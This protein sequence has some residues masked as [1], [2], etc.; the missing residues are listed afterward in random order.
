[1]PVTISS[2]A[3]LV[4]FNNVFGITHPVTL[5]A[6][7][8]LTQGVAFEVSLYNVRAQVKGKTQQ[9]NLTYGTTALMKGTADAVVLSQNKKL[10][11]EWVTGLYV[12]MGSPEAQKAT[13]KA[14]VQTAPIAYRVVLLGVTHPLPHLLKLV[15]AVH[16]VTGGTVAAAKKKVDDAVAGATVEI[17]TYP[18]LEAANIAAA[19][20]TA[21]EGHLQFVP[22]VPP[23]VTVAPPQV[24]GGPGPYAWAK[25]VDQVIDLKAAKAL[26][27]KV[28]GTSTGSVY[29]T[30][31]I[32][33]HVKVAARLYTTGSISIRA[34]WTDNPTGDLKLLAEAG[35]QMKPSYGSIHFDAQDVPLQRVIGA[36]LLGTG[37]EWQQVVTKGA[38]LV[39]GE[40]K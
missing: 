40:Y 21:A 13:L 8:L 1:M 18:S 9:V 19:P 31:A 14:P 10:I 12:S 6:K 34:E 16:S 3:Q 36:F 28:H 17:G 37:I 4:F 5:K 38:D 11:E 39:I 27:Q 26:G 24:V 35:L 7:V 20:I 23:T 2:E 15:K 22:L 32:S 30:I 29:H 33:E 25:P